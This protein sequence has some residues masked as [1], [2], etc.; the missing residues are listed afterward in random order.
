MPK[1]WR[2]LST[3]PVIPLSSKLSPPPQGTSMAAVHLHMLWEDAGNSVTNTEGKGN[4]HL[5]HNY[6]CFDDGPGGGGSL[7]SRQT[8]TPIH[9]PPGGKHWKCVFLT[10]K[11]TFQLSSLDHL[12][13]LRGTMNWRQGWNWASATCHAAN[14][15]HVVPKNSPQRTNWGCG[16][17]WLPGAPPTTARV[18]K[19]GW[20]RVHHSKAPQG[21]LHPLSQVHTQDIMG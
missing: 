13:D 21:T 20:R 5:K 16:A 18:P 9:T 8:P 3:G 4:G 7:C 6:L 1:T 14:V 11:P 10:A 19:A 17:P 15:L 2:K 12:I